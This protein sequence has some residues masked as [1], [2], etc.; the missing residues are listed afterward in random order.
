MMV[1]LSRVYCEDPQ[2][3]R[4]GSGQ[5]FLVGPGVCSCS[6]EGTRKVADLVSWTSSAPSYI[7]VTGVGKNARARL[8][9]KEQV[10]TLKRGDERDKDD[11]GDG[12]DDVD[13]MKREPGR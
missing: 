9:L 7:L 11:G 5:R 10:Q 12:G 6:A 8:S 2:R 13:D 1:G 3:L 4:R